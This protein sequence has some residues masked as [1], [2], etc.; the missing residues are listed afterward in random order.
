MHY[1]PKVTCPLLYTSGVT[2][3]SLRREA[4]RTMVRE[5]SMQSLVLK[6][7]HDMRGA[8]ESAV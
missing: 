5:V 7:G 2:G 1:A 6:N 3:T 8:K 4:A